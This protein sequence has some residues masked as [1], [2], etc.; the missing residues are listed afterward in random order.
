MTE[1]RGGAVGMS[2][3]EESVV[4]E[5]VRDSGSRQ[6][7][8]QAPLPSPA[9]LAAAARSAS[10]LGSEH[11]G[12]WVSNELVTHSISHP[13]QGEISAVSLA[14][15]GEDRKAAVEPL[16]TWQTGVR[17]AQRHPPGSRLA[18]SPATVPWEAVSGTRHGEVGLTDAKNLWERAELWSLGRLLGHQVERP[19]SPGQPHLE[20]GEDPEQLTR[21]HFLELWP[22]RSV[23][24]APWSREEGQATAGKGSRPS[25]SL[26]PWGARVPCS[27][28]FCWQGGVCLLFLIPLMEA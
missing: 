21:R 18:P 23:T 5:P 17:G 20:T 22:W 13:D 14:L 10:N 11:T 12:D 1:G 6:L 24:A 28:G 19:G 3:G 16:Q 9:H 27:P 8:G 25:C 15:L 7:E 2:G 26:T 4:G